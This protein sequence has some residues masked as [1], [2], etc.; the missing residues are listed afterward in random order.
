M[1]RIRQLRAALDQRLD[2]WDAELDAL[3]AQLS[4][5]GEQARDRLQANQHRLAEAARRVEERLEDVADLATDEGRELRRRLEALQVQL[6][7][8]RAES[9][10]AYAQRRQQIDHAIHEAEAG[11]GQFEAH[12]EEDLAD[13][14][15]AFVRAADR[16]RAE[17]EA[18]EVQFALLK[19]EARDRLAAGRDE[20]R[21]QLRQLRGQLD[22]ARR[23]AGNRLEHAEGSLARGLDQ[24]REGLTT[25]I[26]G[27]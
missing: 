2:R 23:E 9:R 5:S 14:V 1:S 22:E 24:L 17:L 21:G 25:L 8:A 15:T 7:L 3:E 6:A 16:L 27:A 4:Q 12:L 11:L 13:E 20:L 19:A 18:G 26:R 10:D